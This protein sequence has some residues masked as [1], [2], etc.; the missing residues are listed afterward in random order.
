MPENRRPYNHPFEQQP[1]RDAD[2]ILENV[3]DRTRFPVETR[4]NM[5]EALRRIVDRELALELNKR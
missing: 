2:D 4:E 1:L 3:M 5:A